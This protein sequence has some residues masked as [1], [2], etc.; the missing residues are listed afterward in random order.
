MKEVNKSRFYLRVSPDKF[1]SS[2]SK[3][4]CILA[5]RRIAE[6]LLK[7]T[8]VRFVLMRYTLFEKESNFFKILSTLKNVQI[9]IQPRDKE[10]RMK[11][12]EK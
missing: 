5:N 12:D 11:I 10:F 2:L 3:S 9:S 7:R 1:K 4:A 6:N 8:F